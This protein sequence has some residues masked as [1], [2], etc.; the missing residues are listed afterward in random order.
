VA[1]GESIHKAAA[2]AIELA[3]HLHLAPQ[4]SQVRIGRLCIVV[5][6]KLF[7]GGKGETETTISLRADSR[8]VHLVLLAEDF[9][10]FEDNGVYLAAS[11]D[12]LGHDAVDAVEL[13]PA[14]DELDADVEDG[15]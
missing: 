12:E 1:A 5:G 9:V 4:V 3:S 8:R 11:E 14:G 15:G 6:L 7:D 2:N 13:E 10:A